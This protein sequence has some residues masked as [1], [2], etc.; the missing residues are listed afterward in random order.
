MKLLAK[1][2]FRVGLPLVG[3]IGIGLVAY[4]FHNLNSITLS[5]SYFLY[6]SILRTIIPFLVVLVIL[7]SLFGYSSPIK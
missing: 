3:L 7:P 1:R 5:S 2:A 6:F 4:S